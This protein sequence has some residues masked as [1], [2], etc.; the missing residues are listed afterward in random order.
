[1][2]GVLGLIAGL[3]SGCIVADVSSFI[4]PLL[5]VLY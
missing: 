2:T 3:A 5:L 4:S 1:L